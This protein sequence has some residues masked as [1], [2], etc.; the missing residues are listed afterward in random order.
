MKKQLLYCVSLISLIMSGCTNNGTTQKE[1]TSNSNKNSYTS[2]STTSDFNSSTNNITIKNI[3]ITEYDEKLEYLKEYNTDS[4]SVKVTYSDN[5]YETYCG[6]D[7]RFD[8]SNFS[9]DELGVHEL[10]VI[11]KELNVSTKFEYEVIPA[12]TLN[13]LMIGNSY[14]DDTSQWVNEICADLGIEVNIG[15]LYIG[16]CSLETHYNNLKN[17]NNAYEFRTY[18]KNTK[19]WKTEKNTSIATALEYYDWEYVTIQQASALSG[20]ES[21]YEYVYDVMDEVWQIKDDVRFIWNMTWAYQEN[22]GHSSFGA[23]GSSQEIMYQSIINTVKSEILTNSDIVTVIPNGTAVQNA[24]TSFVGDNLCRDV[25]CHLSLDLGRYIAGLSLVKTITGIDI[26][27]INFVPLNMNETYKQIAIE[28]VNNEINNPFEVTNSKYDTEPTIDVSNHIEIDYRP[29][30][31]AY[32]HSTATNYNKLITNVEISMN[33]VASKRFTRD[34]LPI[35]SLIEIK[36]GYQYRPDGWVEDV[37][38]TTRPENVT[39]RVVEVDEEWWGEYTLRGF[40]IS[41]TSGGSLMGKMKEAINA[42]SI[43]VPKDANIEVDTSYD[44]D[45]TELFNNNSLDISNYE[46]YKYIYQNGF[47]NSAG[48]ANQQVDYV[49]A[50]ATKFIS[51]ETFTKETLPVGSVIIVDDGYQYRPD[52]WEGNQINNNRPGNVDANFIVVDDEWWSNY[53]VKG[54][55]ISKKDGTNVNIDPY[56]T[57]SHFRIYLPK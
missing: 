7:L 12:K 38:Q 52:A 20:I 48:H 18:D 27:N 21:S 22:S 49:G 44:I 35:G 45:D 5:S 30:G 47:Y 31:C 14:S 16:G 29:V 26:N 28:S 2:E 42:F 36:A 33:F 8:Y 55:N 11:V 43:Y 39:S 19:N 9:N 56:E 57:V 51:T 15:N 46:N 34:E 53:T 25:Y 37:Q 54:F 4:V 17:N 40:N 10:E 1:S 3:E 24:R 50:L 6:D 32:W 41:L 23:Y 13:V